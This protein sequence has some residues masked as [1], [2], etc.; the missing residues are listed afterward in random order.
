MVARLGSFANVARSIDADPSQVSRT[1]AGLE[2]A[3]GIRLFQRTTRQ[4][5]L[6]EAGELYLGRVEVI[7]DELDDARDQALALS[8]KPQGRLRLT[9]SVAFGQICLIP[10]MSKFKNAFPHLDV[11]LV[12]TDENLDLVSDRIDLAIRLAPAIESEVISTKLFGTCYRVC[13][14]P[15]YISTAP[16]FKS[17]DDIINHDTIQYALPDFRERWLFRDVRNK[18]IEVPVKG[19]LNISNALVIRE[20][21]LLGLGP[22]L[23]ADWLIDDAIKAG[24]CVDV[25]PNHQVTA[26]SFETGAWLIY[27]NR[28]FL[29]NKVRVAINFLR[30]H[31]IR[32][33]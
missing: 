9:T 1:I 14:S 4:M 7:V 26:T 3:L 29:P 10:L 6:T 2:N 8:S 15:D 19:T 18:T 13:A 12:L 28:R 32:V 11:D 21:V 30:E 31:L 24:K 33:S 17:P 20:S 23:M 25:F 16:P 27:P 5:K 22:A